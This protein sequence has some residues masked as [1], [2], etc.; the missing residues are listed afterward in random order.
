MTNH[1]IINISLHIYLN[2]M[3]SPIV[4]FFKDTSDIL[5]STPD[6]HDLLKLLVVI[7]AN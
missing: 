1:N 3:P 4:C 5:S 7:D 2:L 6:E